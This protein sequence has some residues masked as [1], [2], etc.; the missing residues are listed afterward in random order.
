SGCYEDWSR[1]MDLR[2][3]ADKYN[4][5]IVCPDGGYAGWYI[6]SPLVEDSQY[7][8]YIS[9]E[10]V[11]FV[12]E[13]YRTIAEKD[14]RVICGLSMGGHGAI[15]MLAR[16]PDIYCAAGSMSGVMELTSSS[17]KYGLTELL[18][19]YRTNKDRWKK[20]SCINLADK[21]VGKNK[22]IIIDCGVD[23][24]L[25]K[26]NR[27]IHK[28]L[29]KLKIDHDYYERPGKH[30]WNYWTNALEYHI[31]FFSKFLKYE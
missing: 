30:S 22:G 19:D 21:L 9:N 24:F 29:L 2:P 13:H 16:H 27:K 25:V 17:K 10:V 14:G 4:L 23:D 11:A 20:N 18:G 6:D 5:I 31:L 28:E 15:S 7:E 3:L 1:H 8:T 26:G 12:D